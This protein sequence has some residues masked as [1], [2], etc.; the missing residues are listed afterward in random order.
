MLIM[1]HAGIPHFGCSRTD[2]LIAPSGGQVCVWVYY[3]CVAGGGAQRGGEGQWVHL[4]FEG[5]ELHGKRGV[6]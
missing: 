1:C 5:E 2:L 3:E 4:I 6:R